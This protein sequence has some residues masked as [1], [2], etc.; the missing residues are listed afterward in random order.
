MA[1][2]SKGGGQD[3]VEQDASKAVAVEPLLLFPRATVRQYYITVETEREKMGKLAEVYDVLELTYQSIIFV[4][5]S[6]TATDLTTYM[7][8][9]GF[10]CTALHGRGM[11]KSVRDHVMNE[12]KAG[13]TQVLIATNV[14]A[15]DVGVLGV[16]LVINYDMPV[17]H[18]TG[19]PDFENYQQRVGR[20]APRGRKGTLINFIC[21]DKDK[22]N[23]IAQREHYPFEIEECLD[24]EKLEF[25]ETPAAEFEA[26]AAAGGPTG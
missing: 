8:D 5:T 23:L 7:R 3:N 13:N 14:L 20:T 16:M 22:Q 26:A 2:E 21:G 12:F 25:G 1:E 24:I 6:K 15:R 10:R 17:E 18:D 19:S 4:N 9:M 11:D